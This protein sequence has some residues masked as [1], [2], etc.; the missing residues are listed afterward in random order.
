[1]KVAHAQIALQVSECAQE[2]DPL[3][4]DVLHPIAVH[5]EQMYQTVSSDQDDGRDFFEGS[6]PN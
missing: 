6:Q 1:M 5:L 3:A 2:G 4:T